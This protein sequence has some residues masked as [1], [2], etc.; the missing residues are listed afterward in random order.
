MEC[1]GCGSQ[2]QMSQD[3]VGG[4]WIS[5]GVEVGGL[6]LREF[7]SKGC[8]SSTASIIVVGDALPVR[9]LPEK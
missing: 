1:F 8:A 9:R 4:L 2:G 6:E 5:V 7:A 3:L